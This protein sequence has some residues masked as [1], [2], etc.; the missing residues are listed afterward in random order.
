MRKLT[1]GRFPATGVADARKEAAAVLAPVWTGEAVAPARKARAPLFRDFA[2]RY[3][4]R[5]GS[6]CTP[7]SLKTFDIYLRGRLM[8]RVGNMRL[9]RIDHARVSAWFDAAS[10]ERLGAANRAFEIRRAMLA[11]RASGASLPRARPTP[12]PTLS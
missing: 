2:A 8:P 4:E 1:L 6:C 11:P 10:A 5:R 3:R 7:S 9:G 12:A